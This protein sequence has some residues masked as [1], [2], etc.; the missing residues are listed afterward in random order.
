MA[1]QLLRQEFKK[2]PKKINWYPYHMRKTM[3]SLDVELKKIQLFVEVR[4]ARVP[5][6]SAN[7]ELIS[8]IPP[9]I[10]RIVVYNKI[11][12]ANSRKSIDLI[13]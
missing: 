5:R 10:K 2:V 7:A 11:D 6:T 12:L 8:L 1:Q 4:D 3:R 13:K 9:H